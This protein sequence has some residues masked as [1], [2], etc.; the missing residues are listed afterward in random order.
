MKP[1]LEV[2]QAIRISKRNGMVLDWYAVGL[3]F[4]CVDV[5]SKITECLWHIHFPEARLF[6]GT[7]DIFRASWFAFPSFF[8]DPFRPPDNIGVMLPCPSL[9]LDVIELLS[10]SISRRENGCKFE[11]FVGHI[12]CFVVA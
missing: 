7:F 2:I 11:S 8:S 3:T 9:G 4:I 6:H 5:E 12:E 1:P 10:F